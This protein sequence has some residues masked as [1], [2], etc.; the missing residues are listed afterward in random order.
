MKII[1]RIIRNKSA[2]EESYIVD[3]DDEDSSTQAFVAVKSFLIN[4]YKKQR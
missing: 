4:H 1:D 2:L 3:I